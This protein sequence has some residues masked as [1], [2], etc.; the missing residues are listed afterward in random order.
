MDGWMDGWMRASTRPRT[1]ERES[2]AV[3]GVARR[4]AM[5]L[6]TLTQSALLAVNAV[7]VLNERRFLAPRGLTMRDVRE[8]GTTS[9]TSAK[10]Q[11]VGL[12]NAAS[13]LRVPLVVLN[14]IV[15]FVKVVFG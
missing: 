1:F 3:G 5:T 2:T 11:M 12:I 8:G 7:A 15:I 14:S 10:G 13:Y 4:V 9:P 6:W